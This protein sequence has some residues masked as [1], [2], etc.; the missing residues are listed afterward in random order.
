MNE[1]IKSPLLYNSVY[2]VS[3]WRHWS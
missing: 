3:H 1:S 2:L